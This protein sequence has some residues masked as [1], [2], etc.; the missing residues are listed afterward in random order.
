MIAGRLIFFCAYFLLC[1]SGRAVALNNT[2]ISKYEQYNKIEQQ[3]YLADKTRS[4]DRTS[5]NNIVAELKAKQAL[6]TTEQGLYLIYFMGYQKAIAGEIKA[7]MAL[8]DRVIEQDEY[9]FLKHRAIITK[10]NIFSTSKN[11]KQGF[12]V[13]NKL[14]PNLNEMKDD[15]T[16]PQALFAVATFYNRLSIY[17]LSQ[18]YIQ[19]L[20]AINPSPQ[21]VCFAN[22]LYV[23]S[24]FF[25]KKLTMKN[26]DESRVA[27]CEAI[28]EIMAAN[29]IHV[30]I[31][32][33]Y[34]NEKEPL[35]AL[36]L[37]LGQLE[38]VKSTQ[39]Y[40]LISKFN[41][42]I[43]QAYFSLGD[44]SEAERYANMVINNIEEDHSSM[45]IVRASKILYQINRNKNNLAQALT[46]HE[47][48]MTHDKLYN[49]DLNKRSITYQ[50]VEENNREKNLQ[51]Q[52][53]DEQ[54]KNLKLEG[55]LHERT[56]EKDQLLILSLLLIVAILA[57]WTY[58]SKITQRQLKKMAEYDEL[59][60]ILNR[61]CFN[62][63]SETAIKYCCQ[64]GQPISLILFDL[65]EFKV[66]NDTYGHQVGD[67]VLKNTI[68]TCQE[69]CRKNDIFGRFGGEEFTILLPGCDHDKAF[70]LAEAC[71][72]VISQIS[73]I[74]TGFDFNISASF[75]I[76][77]CDNGSYTLNEF[78]KA[79]DEAM[80]HAKCSGRNRVS[81][82]GVD[83]P[84][85]TTADA[86]HEET[87]TTSE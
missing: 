40:L 22:M 87:L 37:L 12:I 10:V 46:F 55:I 65:D 28:G 52:I 42:L 61:R 72:S 21:Y 67:W 56:R 30:V 4:S 7:A 83:M 8:L 19:L 41:S 9:E 73:T 27:Q 81:I 18:Q 76:C 59:T 31:A 13:L 44:A 14:L 20:L 16:Y 47:L 39:Y 29:F 79:A 77:S 35:L 48:Y 25:L 82:Y 85:S 58:K 5:F 17:H 24:A 57:Y 74:E 66:I 54:N 23:K 11:Y 15:I 62:E 53:L 6:L 64:S 51:I 33:F 78:I 68:T 3:I 71:R 86:H 34:L 80:Y 63:L 50:I 2:I 45:S 69:L 38:S 70:E 32:E 1:L 26:I 36:N 75:G 84:K 49:D 43:A 60:G